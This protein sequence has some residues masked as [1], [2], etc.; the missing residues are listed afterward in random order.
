VEGDRDL[1]G[2][3]SLTMETRCKCNALQGG[4]SP[5]PA[6]APPCGTFQHVL[7]GFPSKKL[8]AILR[9]GANLHWDFA[10]H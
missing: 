5:T 8:V 4:G 7:P 1:L 6:P 3:G 9:H 10:L 2:S